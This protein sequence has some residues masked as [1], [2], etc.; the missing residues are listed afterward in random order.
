MLSTPPFTPKIAQALANLG[1]A[2]A[3]DVRQINPCH[4]ETEHG[5]RNPICVLAAG[6]C[7]RKPH[8]TATFC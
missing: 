3:Y 6:G 4:A 7:G 2:H 1:I 8:S 5:W